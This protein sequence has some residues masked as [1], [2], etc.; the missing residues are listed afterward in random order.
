MK[1]IDG[2]ARGGLKMF[3][4]TKPYGR[5]DEKPAKIVHTMK[6]GN[7]LVVDDNEV[8]YRVRSNGLYHPYDDL[9][10]SPADLINIPETL[11]RTLP[12]QTR[13]GREVRNICWDY[14]LSRGEV[15]IAA[16][17]RSRDEADNLR[18]Y[19]QEWYADGGEYL[20]TLPPETDNDNDL[21][22]IPEKRKMWGWINIYPSLLCD[23]Q[24]EAN[25]IRGG[26]CIACKFISFTKGKGLND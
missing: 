26:N 23:T 9:V 22:N 14:L 12:V 24:K 18:D 1:F 17:V 25:K 2:I 3:D 8:S 7:H 20:S 4:P 16:I 11:D 6:D 13:D 15:G 21:I 5:R 19:W 10:E